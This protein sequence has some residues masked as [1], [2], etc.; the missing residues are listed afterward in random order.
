[1]VESLSRRPTVQRVSKLLCFMSGMLMA[2]AAHAGQAEGASERIQ[3]NPSHRPKYC[4][5]TA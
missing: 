4:V 2:G 5:N 1:M 3:L